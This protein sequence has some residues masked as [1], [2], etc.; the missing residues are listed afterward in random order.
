MLL[1]RPCLRRWQ[2]HATAAN[3]I[4]TRTDSDRELFTRVTRWRRHG[5]PIEM[6]RLESY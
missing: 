3:L 2:R 5:K 1:V 6:L 4:V